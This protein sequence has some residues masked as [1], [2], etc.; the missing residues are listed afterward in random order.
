MISTMIKSNIT[1]LDKKIIQYVDG[2]QFSINTKKFKVIEKIGEGGHGCIYKGILIED[3]NTKDVAIK[4]ESNINSYLMNE[5]NVYKEI[6]NLKLLNRNFKN[7]FKPFIDFITFGAFQCNNFKYLVTE[8]CPESFADYRKR[9]KN[10]KSDIYNDNISV[11]IN[12]VKGLDYLYSHYYVHNDIKDS[13]LLFSVFG[14]PNTTKLIDFG[15]CKIISSKKSNKIVGTIIFMSR[16]AHVGIYNYTNDLES[17]IFNLL[18]WMDYKLPWIDLTD[19]NSIVEIKNFFINSFNSFIEN[20]FN[21]NYKIFI[22]LLFNHLKEAKLEGSPKYKC[23][24]TLFTQELNNQIKNKKPCSFNLSKNFEKIKPDKNPNFK[25]Y[26]FASNFSEL[27]TFRKENQY[28]LQVA[29]FN[30][31]VNTIRG[32]SYSYL[33]RNKLGHTHSKKLKWNTSSIKSLVSGLRYFMNVVISLNIKEFVLYTINKSFFN[34]F[35]TSNKNNNILRMDKEIKKLLYKYKI[36]V[37]LLNENLKDKLEI[38]K[39]AVAKAQELKE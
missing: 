8:Y 29:F 30:Y 36:H 20:E 7:E 25:L 14:M 1:N 32:F 39:L 9:M 10:S 38:M 6:L 23:L 37:V 35:N 15:L 27:L 2:F 34:C 11:C 17:L 16:D 24:K 21:N 28:N 3:K 19:I 4:V 12:V 5:I 33:Y 18:F 31:E 26:N 13:N 22:S